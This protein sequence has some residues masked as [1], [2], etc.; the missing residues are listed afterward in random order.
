MSFRITHVI[1]LVTICSGVA[2]FRPAVAQLSPQD[3][4]TS[5]GRYRV[6]TEILSYLW[7][8]ATSGSV[9]FDAGN[10]S[11][12]V[13][14]DSGPPSPSDLAHSLHNAALAEGLLRYGPFSAELGLNWVFGF[15]TSAF[16]LTRLGTSGSAS[17]SV[18]LF[19]AAPGFGYQV[20]SGQ[21]G[22]VPLTV[23]AR[24]GF[25]VLSWKATSK[26]ARSP[27][28]GLDVSHTFVQPWIGFRASIYPWKDWRFELA[29]TGD[30]F[31]VDG[32]VWGWSASALA[33]YSMTSWLDVTGGFRALATDGRNN[34]STVMR[35]LDLTAYGPVVG[36]GVRF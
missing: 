2:S 10:R 18:K 13:D 7:L 12:S 34:G 20:Y 21:V 5:D 17:E 23:D 33:S 8:P 32:G 36:L 15:N 24:A 3:G 35:S 31:S 14:F 19:S 11:R 27:L 16:Q 29:A 1:G 22:D 4:Y 9:S 30:G 26:F 6:Q 25:S 28:D